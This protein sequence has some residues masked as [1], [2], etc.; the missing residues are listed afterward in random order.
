MKLSIVLGTLLIGFS[1]VAVRLAASPL[2]APTKG[3]EG[4]IRELEA[5]LVAAWGRRDV[6]AVGDVLAED[7]QYWSFSGVRR[8]KAELLKA[9]AESGDGEMV[10]EDAVVRVYGDAAVYTARI[11]DRSAGGAGAVSTSRTCVTDV[12][13][14]QGGRWRMVA[15]HETLLPDGGK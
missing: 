9:V 6:K 5:G 13:V 3:D 2:S 10:T 1:G 7:F 4:A 14:R 12:F 11:V 15:S 8:A